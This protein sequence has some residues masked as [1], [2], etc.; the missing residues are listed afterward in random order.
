MALYN[1]IYDPKQ[2]QVGFA[3]KYFPFMALSPNLRRMIQFSGS[4]T[5]TKAELELQLN[6]D[7]TQLLNS[8]GDWE[9]VWRNNATPTLLEYSRW[10]DNQELEVELRRTNL[11]GKVAILHRKIRIAELSHDSIHSHHPY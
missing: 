8:A 10:A 2:T 6:E 7:K 5:I 9:I 4:H 1:C 11:H 3:L